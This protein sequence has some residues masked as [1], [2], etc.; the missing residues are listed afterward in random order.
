M[1]TLSFGKK[2]PRNFVAKNMPKNKVERMRP[3]KVKR[4]RQKTD[5]KREVSRIY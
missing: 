3:H 5:L 4:Q 2:V 1:F